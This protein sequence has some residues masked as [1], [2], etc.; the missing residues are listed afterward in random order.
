VQHRQERVYI[1]TDRHRISGCLT[2]PAEGYRS[3]LSDF[4]NGSERD[5]VSL[6][7]VVVELIGRDGPGTAHDFMAVARRHI[8]FAIPESGL[9]AGV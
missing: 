8:V 7:D 5:F 3:R 4:L 2:L 9:N 1:E 6:T